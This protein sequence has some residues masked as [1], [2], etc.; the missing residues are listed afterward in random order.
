M[1]LRFRERVNIPLRCP[2]SP[3]AVK[4]DSFVVGLVCSVGVE[5]SL[6]SGL[7]LREDEEVRFRSLLS[8]KLRLVELLLSRDDGIRMYFEDDA[9]GGVWVSRSSF[10]ELD[11]VVVVSSEAA[12]PGIAF[13]LEG[14]SL[15][16]SFVTPS[17]VCCSCCC[18]CCSSR[19]SRVWLILLPSC[20]VPK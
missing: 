11:V 20:V 7:V 9:T 10:E 19:M 3:P 12:A 1:S 15:F 4:H 13:N 14:S 18:C 8:Q 5:S 2:G 16:G 6:L 17:S